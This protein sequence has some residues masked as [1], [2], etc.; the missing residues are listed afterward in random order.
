MRE[1]SLEKVCFIIVKSRE[2]DAK[3]DIGG[4]VDPSNPVDDE[5]VDVLAAG[6]GAE[7]EELVGAI[8]D[9]ND[10]EQAELVA[11][12]LVGREDFSEEEWDDAIEEAANVAGNN[13][14][15]YLV[16]MPLLGDY[17]ESG[18]ATFGLDCTSLEE[19]NVTP[20]AE[21]P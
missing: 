16:G 3:V 12:A 13:A 15:G 20:P 18:L 11:L 4:E 6:N 2:V 9:L 14:V 10:D 19:Q 7:E 1:L 5:E 17:L 21:E 8:E